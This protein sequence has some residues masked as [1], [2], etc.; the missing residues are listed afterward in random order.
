MRQLLYAA[1]LFF[2]L[3][4]AFPAWSGEGHARPG[5]G[6]SGEYNDN[7]R[8][9][10][11]N[12]QTDF[13]THIRPSIEAEYEGGRIK[14]NLEYTGDYMFHARG[15]DTD[16]YRHNLRASLNMELVEK[17]FFLDLREELMPVYRSAALG[18]Y[19]EGDTTR[20]M[21]NRNQFIVSP[22]F[23]LH[24]SERTELRLGYT[25]MDQRYSQ[26]NN[27]GGATG[28]S[29]LWGDNYDFNDNVAWQH[30]LF[31]DL[32]HEATDRLTLL[33][34]GS[35]QIWDGEKDKSGYDPDFTRY[36][37]YLGGAYEFDD[38][39][40]FSL[41]GGPTYTKRARDEGKFWPYVDAKLT[42]AV[43]R[44]LLGASYVMDFTDDPDTGESLE[45]SA[46][47]IWWEKN[48]DRSRLTTSLGYHTYKGE[49]TL[50]DRDDS[51]IRPSIA[52]TYDLSERLSAY[53]RASADFQDGKSNYGDRYFG[54]VGLKYQLAED[55]LLDLSYALKH[56]SKSENMGSYDV[57]RVILTLTVYF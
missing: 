53:A 20:D 4:P 35:A 7:V 51:S 19:M 50:G 52:Y 14:A 56:V 37:G 15:R 5:I 21:V 43:G 16:E 11:N 31:A 6:I 8:E 36:Q 2:V 41:R 24:P 39:W 44:S 54:T 17:L 28:P 45:H 48:F 10:D 40:V 3:A 32:R 29:S 47:N 33:A 25:F 12:P 46:Y 18:D 27:S 1:S 42:L 9:T 38:G 26:P 22:F 13:I 55:V 30:L 49:T 34:G 57:N 23:M